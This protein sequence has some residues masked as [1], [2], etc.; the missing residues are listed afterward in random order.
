MLQSINYVDDVI[1]KEI[2]EMLSGSI[3]II[4]EILIDVDS[5][6]SNY[7]KDKRFS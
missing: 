5:I 4:L 3:S 2:L 1:N 7:S 6:L